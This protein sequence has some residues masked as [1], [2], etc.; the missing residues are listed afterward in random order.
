MSHGINTATQNTTLLA[1]LVNAVAPTS[2]HDIRLILSFEM[3]MQYAGQYGYEVQC[4][5]FIL[6]YNT[7]RSPD[8]LSL[9]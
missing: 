6:D 8:H 7:E 4:P 1:S 3:N 9:R 2:V 5:W